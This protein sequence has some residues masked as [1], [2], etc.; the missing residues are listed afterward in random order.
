MLLAVD[1]GNT[2]IT[3]GVFDGTKLKATGRIATDVH[4]MP[5]EYAVLLHGLLNLQKVSPNQLNK[6]IICSVV[7][8]LLAPFEELCQRYFN[9][10]PL[11]VGAGIKTG[12]RILYESPRDVGA[13]RVVDAVAA[14]RLYGGPVIVVDLGTALVLDAIS[15][16]GDYL[17]GAIAPGLGIAAEALSSRTAKLPKVELVRP[18]HAIGKNTVAAMQ[19][20]LIFG[21]VG[22]VE[23][24][25]ARFQK[26]M[27]GKAKVVAT[28]GQATTLAKETK[29]F[30]AVNPDLTL[31][32][33][34]IVYALNA[35]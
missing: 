5:D 33:L 12:I 8:P 22:L 10:T 4:K 20:G 25:V 31:Q 30:D 34:Q 7:P 14:H 18:R 3:L 6:A 32:G 19:S 13:D 24:L 16:E 15:E 26:E 9:I 23:G 21:Y 28:G 27:G 1:I 35:P 11:V 17:G 2:N 29:I